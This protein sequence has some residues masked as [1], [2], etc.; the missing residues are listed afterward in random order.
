MID[1]GL[2]YPRSSKDAKLV[3]FSDSNQTGDID[4]RKSM[5]GALFFLSGSLVSW[6][7]AK[8]RVLVVSSCEVEYVAAT[9]VASQTIWLARLL[10]DM[11]GKR[12][13][14]SVLALSKNPVSMS[15]SS[16]PT[17]G[18]ISSTNVWRMGATL[19]ISLASR[20]SSQTS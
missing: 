15:R 8:Q 2:S 10:G 6:Q 18:I 11:K 17:F 16:I 3:G 9:T 1:Y 5:S 4:I 14:M 20:T 13:T 12:D 7:S 19:L